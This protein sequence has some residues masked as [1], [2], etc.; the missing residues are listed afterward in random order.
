MVPIVALS[1]NRH[2]LIMLIENALHSLVERVGLWP[3]LSIIALS[4]VRW[5]RYDTS[6]M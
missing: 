4:F 6:Y 2:I 1:G 3:V 5:T